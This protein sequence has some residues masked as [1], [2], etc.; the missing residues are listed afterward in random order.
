[1]ISGKIP[2]GYKQAEVGVIPED[3]DVKNI[4]SICQIFGRIGFSTLQIIL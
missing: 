4:G 3:W 1:M 2:K